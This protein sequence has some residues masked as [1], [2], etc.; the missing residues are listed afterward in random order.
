MDVIL[1]LSS[2]SWGGEG[3]VRGQGRAAVVY[4][5]EA[6]KVLDL[7][8]ISRRSDVLNVDCGSHSERGG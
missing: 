2:V 5:P 6:E 8:V 7:L 4:I 3:R 1:P